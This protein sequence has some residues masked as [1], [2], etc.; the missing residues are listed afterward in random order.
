MTISS[1]DGQRSARMSR[2][3]FLTAT[4]A[5]PMAVAVW[6]T[7]WGG[8]VSSIRAAEAVTGRID[9][10]AVLRP[11]SPLIYGV[12]WD[13]NGLRPGLL[14]WG[15][16]FSSRY[17]WELGSAFNSAADY[18]FRNQD[19]GG[20]PSAAR[21][22]SG[23][24]DLFVEEARGLGV[25]V[26]LTVPAL[27][28]VARD[29]S[30]DNRSLEVPKEGGP[31]IAQSAG[32]GQ[33]H[34]G[35]IAGYDPTLNRRR[36]SLRSLPRKGAAFQFPPDLGDDVVYQDEWIA[37]LTATFGPASD[38][39]GRYY[40]IDNE[41]DIWSVTH[42][43]VHPG[44]MGFS[45]M[46]NIFLEYATAIKD[47][48]PTAQILGPEL[49]G[50][51]WLTY[52]ELDRGQDR[53]QT[54]SDRALH[55]QAF[56]P[57]FLQQ[58]RSHD[59]ATGRRTLDVLSVHWYPQGGEFMGPNAGE[60]AERRLRAPRQLWDP[61]YQDE[62]WIA[63]TPDAAPSGSVRLIPR[64][65]EW[66]D[67]HYPGTRLGLMEWNYGADD[68]LNGALVVADVLGIL[69][70]EG[71]DMAAY[72]RAPKA[73]TPGAWAWALYRNFD[74]GGGTFGDQAL[75]VDRPE[76]HSGPVSIFAS[77][78]SQSGELR[79]ILI[80]K[81]G[82]VA[83]A[84]LSIDGASGPARLYRYDGANLGGIVRLGDLPVRGGRMSLNLPPFSLSL[85]AV[86]R[87]GG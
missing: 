83:P 26:V 52:S 41:P 33:G 73:G 54:A 24:A 64:L 80:N 50:W 44:Q 11:I 71:V 45:D 35:T 75:A 2:R 22:P 37:H 5:S 66:I 10:N 61:N 34:Q 9:P 4:V 40:S 87:G 8:G 3:A 78:D 56:L 23:M 15:G 29:M 1:G 86:G 62:S 69:G 25:P 58:V 7:G 70:R 13:Q 68:T 60:I 77:R 36:T 72:W 32:G 14:R 31:P 65:R 84:N 55:G 6:W 42:R 85:I 12:S 47:V 18:E 28:W 30:L 17:N 39:F 20:E 82:E 27:G 49:A 63:G 51:T 74:G 53:F 16:N 59:E 21:N 76:G 57:F 46:I 19:Y 79:V 38:G 43:D 81:Q 48:D 67:T